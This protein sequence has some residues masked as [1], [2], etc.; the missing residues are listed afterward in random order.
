LLSE[1]ESVNA[2]DKEQIQNP[3]L[4]YQNSE[5]GIHVDLYDLKIKKQAELM[6]IILTILYEFFQKVNQMFPEHKE[7]HRIFFEKI[8]IFIKKLAF[9]IEKSINDALFNHHLKNILKLTQSYKD[10]DIVQMIFVPFKL[11]KN[12]LINI[13]VMHIYFKQLK[14]F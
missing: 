10:Q 9:R 5:F 7:I 14:N 3:K 1:N 8:K 12:N 4:F 2:E 11:M 6:S 13:P